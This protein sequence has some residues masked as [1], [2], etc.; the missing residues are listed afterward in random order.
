MSRQSRHAR[1]C[2]HERLPR[3][4]EIWRG[5]DHGG[6][7]ALDS[8]INLGHLSQSRDGL[9]SPG[10][11]NDCRKCHDTDGPGRSIR[12]NGQEYYAEE[13]DDLS[14]PP[15]ERHSNQRGSPRNDASHGPVVTSS[16]IL[17]IAR[18][19]MPSTWIRS[20]TDRK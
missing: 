6:R 3:A 15:A 4:G 5:Y 8:T 1:Y 17:S 9:G 18:S 7:S 13:R 11:K 16:R 12:A 20:S 14:A 10:A 2:N 19:E